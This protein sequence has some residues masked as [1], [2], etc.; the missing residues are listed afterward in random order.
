MA[1]NI[2]QS[3]RLDF[4]AHRG[5]LLDINFI[6][7]DINGPVDLT[8]MS[9]EFLLYDSGGNFA[10][11]DINAGIALFENSWRVNRAGV[12][13]DFEVI[14]S[15]RFIVDGREWF[16]GNLDYRP[17]TGLVQE[18]YQVDVNL[19]G[20]ININVAL[21][22]VAAGATGGTA[23]T[24]ENVTDAYEANVDVVRFTPTLHSKLHDAAS[25]TELNNLATDVSE[26]FVAQET[27]NSN[28]WAE[29]EKLKLLIGD[30]TE[31]DVPV[32]I[33]PKAPTEGLIERLRWAPNTLI[34][35]WYPAPHTFTVLEHTIR[36]TSAP[37]GCMF[38]VDSLA[39]GFSG[40][41]LVFR[42]GDMT[43]VEDTPNQQEC[44]IRYYH[45]NV[46]NQD[47]KITYYIEE[48]NDGKMAELMLAVNG[49]WLSKNTNG[50]I[51]NIFSNPI[52]GYGVRQGAIGG[53]VPDANLT[54]VSLLS[55]MVLYSG[56]KPN[57][58]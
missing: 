16:H 9:P 56:Q 36:I 22:S 58:N 38:D 23:I 51:T 30:T 5:E 24:T 55:D 12:L 17:T 47:L 40:D 15:Y 1:I 21:G 8:A 49:L 4:K 54:G 29:I 31:P 19:T 33:Y 41:Y 32:T 39:I 20:D 48:A 34:N 45:L 46:W 2:E 37:S 43:A 27:V 13:N 42:V 52:G 44:F 53:G 3:R 18:S 10:K 57:F 6:V 25:I 11:L 14:L 28:L 7:T 35:S 50:Y 26:D